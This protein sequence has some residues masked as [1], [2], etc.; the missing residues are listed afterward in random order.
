MSLKKALPLCEQSLLLVAILFARKEL[1]DI[2]AI[3][4]DE[5]R[6]R[7]SEVASKFLLMP[8][9]ERINKIILELKRQFFTEKTS[10]YIIHPSW[11]NEALD[12][13]PKYLKELIKNALP[14]QDPHSTN[15]SNALVTQNLLK[16][17]F[18]LQFDYQ[19]KKRAIFDPVLMR[20]QSSSDDENRKLLARVGAQSIRLLSA[21]L[22]VHRF[23]TF[24]QRRD[25]IVDLSDIPAK[26]SP[27]FDFQPFRSYIIKKI[28]K[29]ASESIQDI[30]LMMVAAYLSTLDRSWH[31]SI[32][33]SMESVLGLRIKYLVSEVADLKMP[34]RRNDLFELLNNEAKAFAA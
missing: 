22:N 29:N 9:N 8:Q 18:M 3:F 6:S 23:R 5:Q 27:I 15:D 1:N 2:L 17:S 19:A 4:P 33:F 24:L 14:N 12:R 10:R 25:V 7:M 11:V 26:K 30:G 21:W 32:V 16:T 20:L 31:D 34:S 13:E 28:H